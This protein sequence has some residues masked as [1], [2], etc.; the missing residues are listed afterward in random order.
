MVLRILDSLATDLVLTIETAA[1]K[2]GVSTA[3]AHRALVELA[4]VGILSRTKDHKGKVICWTADQHLALIALTERSNRVG[5]GDTEVR[6]PH[7]GPPAPARHRAT[8]DRA[9]Q[10]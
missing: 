10:G 5:A 6:R 9:A 2:H 1:R 3:A 8:P 4:K 7:L